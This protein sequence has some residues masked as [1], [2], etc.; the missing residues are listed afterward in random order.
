M[1]DIKRSDVES[2]AG[3]LEH[4]SEGLSSQEQQVLDW[5]LARARN[6]SAELSDAD[7]DTV[8]GGGLL[9]SLGFDPADESVKVGWTLSK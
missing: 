1:A 8:A 4:F 5:I 7:L 3:K 6:A 9:E 2:L